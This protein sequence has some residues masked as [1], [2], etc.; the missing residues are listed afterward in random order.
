[1]L[2][3]YIFACILFLVLDQIFIYLNQR[4]LHNQVINVQR[5]II[6]LNYSAAIFTYLLLFIALCYFIIRSHRGIEEAFLLGVLINGSFEFTNMSI[7][8]KWELKNAILDTVWGGISF[9]LATKL[10]Y[11]FFSR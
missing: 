1:M 4:E 5:V 2:E 3:R 9:A 11:L 6:Q 8:K 7:F 10:T